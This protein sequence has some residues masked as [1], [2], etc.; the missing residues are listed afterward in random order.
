[1]PHTSLHLILTV[2]YVLYSKEIFRPSNLDIALFS[3]KFYQSYALGIVPYSST[4]PPDT[5]D[6][7]FE[8]V[9]SC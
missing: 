9:W 2:N 7:R 8:Q 1:M 5:I 6:M 4:N 3:P